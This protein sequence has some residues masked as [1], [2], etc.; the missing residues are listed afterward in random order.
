MAHVLISNYVILESMHYIFVG[1]IRNR[2]FTI[3]QRKVMLKLNRSC[4][5]SVVVSVA[6][7]A[8]V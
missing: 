2:R 1:T 5:Y 8:E 6:A 4:G 7:A 3:T